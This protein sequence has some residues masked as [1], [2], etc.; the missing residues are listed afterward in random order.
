MGWKQLR[1]SLRDE[2]TSARHAGIFE[3]AR[4]REPALVPHGTILS[5]LAALADDS[6]RHYA[7]RDA[8]TRALLAE[9][10]R[11][12]RAF[13]HAALLLAYAPMLMRLRGRLIGATFTADD[14]DQL[15]LESFLRVVS[16]F[17]LERRPTR[18]AMHL[19]Q[20]TQRAVFRSLCREQDYQKQ[21]LELEE[22]ASRDDDFE[23][24]VPDPG[25]GTLLED[26][27]EE[28]ARLLVA[29][30][31]GTVPEKLL[32]IVI[33]TELGDERVGTY[34]K[35]THPALEGAA[36][37]A[38][39][40]RVKRQRLRTLE[41]LRPVLKAAAMSPREEVAALQSGSASH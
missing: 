3:E 5:A 37:E 19:R 9:H 2:V 31:A 33:A 8:V 39:Y 11:S 7:E 38:V 1:S 25:D 14:L 12:P 17:P 36:I 32:Q 20:D 34:V 30:G 35:R 22:M 6:E 15:V 16:R 18:V 21:L 27:R 26:E 29:L 13:W 4:S 10:Q 28:L 41:R 24:F 23:V 40:Q